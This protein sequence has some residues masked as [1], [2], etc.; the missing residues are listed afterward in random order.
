[1]RLRLAVA[2]L[3]ATSAGAQDKPTMEQT[4]NWLATKIAEEGGGTSTIKTTGA[5]PDESTDISA[6]RDVAIQD[7]KLTYTIITNETSTSGKS[8]RKSVMTV[9]LAKVREDDVKVVHVP[10]VQPNSPLEMRGERW[11]VG[12][13]TPVLDGITTE[14]PEGTAGADKVR[15]FHNVHDAIY[16]GKSPSTDEDT[17]NRVQKALKYVV[18]LCRDAAKQTKE[19]F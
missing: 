9:P 12:I 4:A 19:P 11:N 18:S 5:M 14:T 6:Y 16:F 15:V 10:P 1:M 7:C 3:L 13:G 2:M 8:H 17:A